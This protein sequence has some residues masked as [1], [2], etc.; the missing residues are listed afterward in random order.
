[1]WNLRDRKVS[2]F[3][4][5][6]KNVFVKALFSAMIYKDYLPFTLQD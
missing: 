3:I 4:L 1:L 2:F 6:P 5:V